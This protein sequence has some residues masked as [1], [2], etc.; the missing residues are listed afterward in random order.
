MRKKDKLF[1]GGKISE[2]CGANKLSSNFKNSNLNLTSTSRPNPFQ[3]KTS[4]G[5]WTTEKK[6][7]GNGER[8]EMKLRGPWLPFLIC[9]ETK[10]GRI[11][12]VV[13]AGE[14]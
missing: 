5:Q 3:V 14:R 4:H 8:T 9:R 13:A 2:R 7:V 1:V 6:S 10:Q 12:G 11:M